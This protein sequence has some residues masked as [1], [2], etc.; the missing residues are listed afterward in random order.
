MFKFSLSY[1]M[2]FEASLGYTK[3]CLN[4]APGGR[5]WFVSIPLGSY[6]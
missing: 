4:L 1:I 5:E 3:P 2:I 6:P